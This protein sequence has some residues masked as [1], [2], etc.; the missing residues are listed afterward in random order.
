MEQHGAIAF[1]AINTHIEKLLRD[2]LS[3]IK[4]D[5]RAELVDITTLLR[6]SLVGEGFFP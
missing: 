4:H 2:A 6:L 3:K 5:I 1:N